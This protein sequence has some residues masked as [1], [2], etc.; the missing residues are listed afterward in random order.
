MIS[1]INTIKAYRDIT[2]RY[3][4]SDVFMTKINV[5]FLSYGIGSEAEFWY[6]LVQN[7]VSGIICRYGADCIISMSDIAD[8][9]E[10]SEF[11]D[12]IGF[13]SI[14]CS[15]KLPIPGNAVT[16]FIMRFQNNN[17]HSAPNIIRYSNYKELYRFLK[18]IDST[19]IQLPD[20]ADFVTS[21]YARVRTNTAQIRA[22]LDNDRI[23]AVCISMSD[24]KNTVIS[25]IA[26]A[27]EYRRQGFALSL[28]NSI[29]ENI[30]L[31]CSEENL[32]F[33]NKIGFEAVGKWSELYR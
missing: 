17:A 32:P 11:L 24:G 25:P 14:L 2:S 21:L 31:L 19:E 5:L 7:R 13:R 22:I 3:A 16:G 6:Q 27:K 23:I 30:L 1:Y 20:Y 8:M 18:S 10:I 12:L 4:V 26:T 9:T 33:Y 29:S 28:I 15:D